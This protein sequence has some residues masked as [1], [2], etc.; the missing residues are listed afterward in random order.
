VLPAGA[1]AV[2]WDGRDGQGRE[3]ASGMYYA[4]T[5]HAGGRA[6]A[7]VVRVR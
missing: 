5:E 1:S 2:W 4:R 7:R 3:A 6:A